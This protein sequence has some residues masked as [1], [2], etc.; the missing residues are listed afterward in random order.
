MTWREFNKWLRGR[1]YICMESAWWYGAN[2]K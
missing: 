1:D 2:F